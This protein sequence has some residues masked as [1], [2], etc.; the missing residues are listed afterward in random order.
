MRAAARQAGDTPPKQYQ[1]I[2]GI[3]I[4]SQSI[5]PFISCANINNIVVVISPDD[6]DLFQQGRL[7]RQS[8]Y[9][10]PWWQNPSESVSLV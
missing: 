8:D 5:N 2:N 7:R 4:I 3:S 6:Q 9:T 1:K 10:C